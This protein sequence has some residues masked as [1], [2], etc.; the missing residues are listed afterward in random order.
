MRSGV[1]ISPLSKYKNILRVKGTLREYNTALKYQNIAN[2]SFY[3]NPKYNADS[4]VKIYACNNATNSSI[5]AIKKTRYRGWYNA[6]TIVKMR[7]FALI[8][9]LTDDGDFLQMY[10]VI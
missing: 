10:I 2:K 7:D 5:M 9:T 6:T 4:N 1:M 3:H 8:Y